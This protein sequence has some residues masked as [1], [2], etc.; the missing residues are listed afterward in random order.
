MSEYRYPSEAIILA[1]TFLL[2]G[3]LLVLTAIP[4]FC[5]APAL[6][7]VFIA[8][9]YFS[10]QSHHRQ[11]MQ[12]A[13]LV[14]P[15]SAPA[16]ANAIET[17]KRRLDE[18]DVEVY[19]LNT[20]ERNAYTFGITEPQVV[21]IYSPL[22]TIMD[23]DEIKFVIGHELGHVVLGHTWLNTIIGG[24]AGVPSSFAVAVIITLIFRAW[25]RACEYSAD[26]AGLLACGNLNKAVLALVEIVAGDIRSQVQF[27]NA[28]AAIDAEDDSFTGI[29]SESLS[30]HPM[31]IKRI[32]ELQSYAASDEGKRAMAKRAGK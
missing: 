25:N 11:I 9:A 20:R 13:Q 28:L 27:Q 17:C 18:K 15:Q 23:E 21:V 5:L 14:T 4:T 31:L 26:R 32:K 2:L 3:G 1:V 24:M 12:Q 8:M 16:L 30:S 7:I 6:V 22:L 10:N 29:L 19:V